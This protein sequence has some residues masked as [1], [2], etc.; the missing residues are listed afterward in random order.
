[1]ITKKQILSTDFCALIQIYEDTEIKKEPTYF[2]KLL[3]ETGLP[4]MQLH[5][6][7]DRLYDKIMIDM[8]VVKIEGGDQVI[9][10][11]ISEDFLPFTEGLYKATEE[12]INEQQVSPDTKKYEKAVEPYVKEYSKMES[13]NTLT[14]SKK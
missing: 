8:Q 9:G 12:V 11:T 7:L 2:T 13:T 5:K 6:S 14:L 1:M 3:K 4:S 10:F